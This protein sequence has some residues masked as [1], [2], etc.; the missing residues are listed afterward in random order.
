[1][2]ERAAQLETTRQR[3]V[4]AAIELYTDVGI[5]AATMREIALRADVAPG[6]LRH[7]F[8]A[9]EALEQAMIERLTAEIPLPDLS[10]FDGADTIDERLARLVLATGTFLDQA[11]RLYRMW[12]REPMVTGPWAETGAAYGARWD[13]LTRFALGSL[14]DDADSRAILRAISEPTLFETLRAGGA[15][16]TEQV[17]A[18]ITELIVPWFRARSA[19]AR[20][21]MPREGRTSARSRDSARGR[22]SS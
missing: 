12:M 9:R 3:I 20:A 5:S 19:Q 17:C 4:D 1:M 2:G 14:G 13:E 11:R 8:P 21:A 22:T 10:M 7:H 18:L 15:R 16:T 6:T